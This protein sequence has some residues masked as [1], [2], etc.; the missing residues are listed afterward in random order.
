MDIDRRSQRWDWSWLG[1]ILLLL[2]HTTPQPCRAQIVPDGTLG[3]QASTLTVS[4]PIETVQGGLQRGNHLFHSFL[5]FNV[6]AGRSVVFRNPGVTNI[7]A[8][9]TGTQPSAINGL[10]QIEGN[11]NFFLINPNGIKFGTGARLEIAGSFVAATAPAIPFSDG[12][13]FS[14]TSPTVPNVLTIAVPLGLQ[15]GAAPSQGA[16]VNQGVLR[17][18][19]DLTLVADRV[20]VPGSLQAGRNL[21]LVANT[22]QVS[23]RNQSAA[24]AQAQGNLLVQSQVLNLSGGG[25]LR[26]A[27]A[28]VGQDS[29]ILLGTPDRPIQQITISGPGSGL[30]TNISPNSSSGSSNPFNNIS[31]NQTSN[32]LSNQGGD[33][34][35]FAD[36]LS[37]VNQGQI[38]ASTRGARNAGTILARVKGAIQLE[39]GTIANGVEAN[40]SGN[41]GLIDLTADALTVKQRG[42]IRSGTVGTGNAGDIRIQAQTVAL[43]DGRIA[44]GSGGRD[45]IGLPQTRS[46]GAGGNLSL[47]T[48]S[49]TV[50]DDGILSATTF[51]NGAGGDINIT[52]ATVALM[53]RGQIAATTESTGDA[54]SITLNARDRVTISGAPS[55]IF[56]NTG[57]T[58]KTQATGQGGS[59]RVTT[60]DLLLDNRARITVDSQGLGQ[61]GDIQLV[62]HRVTLRDQATIFA[63]T[64]STQGGNITIKAQDFLLL[65]RNSLISA[66][67]GT[68]QAGGD[69]GNIQIRSGFVVGL[70]A[71]NS[72]IIANAFRGDGGQIAI[73]T[74]G[75]F[76]LQFQLQGTPLS[77]ITASSQFGNS[78]SVLITTLNVDPNQ[79][80][81]ALPSEIADSTQQIAQTCSGQQL[82]NRFVIL[83]RGGLSP[84]RSEVLNQTLVWTDPAMAHQ[85]G[86]NLQKTEG[87][88]ERSKIVEITG[89]T[90][91]SDGSIVLVADTIELETDYLIATLPSAARLSPSISACSHRQ[92]PQNR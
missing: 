18:G 43:Q 88:S 63:E 23:R 3:S 72:D 73:T 11:A 22:V 66:S 46:F 55:G 12:S 4:G 32:L 91:R 89:W 45:L 42:Q 16:I 48:D 59:I 6:G 7:L 62:A 70:L 76:G 53:N 54:G 71:E 47:T 36:A 82:Q 34:K 68:A 39:N 27:D 44:S 35:I 8:R 64:A 24:L 1:G 69:G 21:T 9:V 80:L 79:G 15:L 51:T 10:L 41:G 38:N 29:A 19:Q 49:L 2:P 50:T 25:Q 13:L 90:Q 85:S 65:R 74:Q 57:F 67:A 5:N 14:A 61:G 58:A 84:D 26:I 37:V 78:G 86:L 77:D 28:L 60:G 87:V 75:L 81:V 56:A 20:E 92:T 83:G 33:I 30:F 31:S 40:A 52:A 17:T